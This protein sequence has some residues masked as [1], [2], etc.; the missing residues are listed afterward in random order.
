MANFILKLLHISQEQTYNIQNENRHE[1]TKRNSQ[2]Y[3]MQMNIH[4]SKNPF[5]TYHT[6]KTHKYVNVNERKGEQGGD[7]ETKSNHME[8]Y[9][10]DDFLQDD[11]LICLNRIPNESISI[12]FESAQ[13]ADERTGAIKMT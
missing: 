9:F 12:F 1:A 4:A 10:M 13:R 7:R 5:V 8:M 2:E 11:R 3:D 6:N